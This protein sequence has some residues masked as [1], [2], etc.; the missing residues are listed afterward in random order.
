MNWFIPALVKSSVG[1]SPG[2]SGLLGDH[3]VA[4]LSRSTSGRTREFPGD[5]SRYC[6]SS[7]DPSERSFKIASRREALRRRG[8]GRRGRGPCRRAPSAS[9]RA[10][11][12]RAPDRAARSSSTSSKTSLHGVFRGVAVD[13]GLRIFWIT[14]D[15]AAVLDG[16]FHPRSGQRDAAVVERADPP[17]GARWRRRSRRRRAAAASAACAAALPTARAPRGASAQRCRRL[18]LRNRP[19]FQVPKRPNACNLGVA[20]LGPD[21]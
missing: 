6:I 1:S 14:R 10:A 8:R 9:C 11:A 3:A 2:S 19:R 20:W 5:A 4:V 15:A 7:V 17:S 13:A 18:P 12:A 21:R 16:A